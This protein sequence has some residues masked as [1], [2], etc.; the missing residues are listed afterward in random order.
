[1]TRF[2]PTG[3]IL[4]AL[5]AA[6]AGCAARTDVSTTGSTPAQFT[7][8]FITTQEVWFNKNSGATA[9]DSGWSKF[10]LNTPITVDLVQ[11][12]GT[13]A[14]VANDL[15]LGPGTYNSILLL[16]VTAVSPTASAQAAG[17]QFN[18]EADF[19]DSAGTHQVALIL[20]NPEK[21]IAVPGSLKVPVG[22]V[23][24]TGLGTP[25]STGTTNA[26]QTPFGAPTTVNPTTPTTI[27]TTTNNTVT[28]S[29]AASFDG[30]RDLHMFNYPTGT[31][32][33]T[34][35]TGVLLSASPTASD[36]STA[37]AISGT[38]SLTTI[39]N[40]PT[41]P[42]TSNT[43]SARTA[44]WASAET[45]SADGLHRV[46]VASAPV[47]SGGNFSIYPLNTSS[48]NPTVYDVVIHG[49]N[50]QTIII[51]GVS[52]TTTSPNFQFGANTTGSVNTTT[53]S[54]SVSLGTL[55]PTSTTSY[56]V[57]LT[58]NIGATL[59]GGAAITFYQTLP[60]DSA[61][62]VIDEVALDPVT[63]TLIPNSEA[64]STSIN[65]TTGSPSGVVTATFS[66]NGGTLSP[67]GVTPVE[68]SGVYGVGATAPLYTDG[69]P[70]STVSAAK[71]ATCPTVS[72]TTGSTTTATTT[73]APL[74]ASIASV[75]SLTPANSA[76][77]ASITASI[78]DSQGDDQGTL[79]VSRNGAVIGTA[80]L[81]PHLPS[82]SVT[83]NGLPGGNTYY[84]S[85]IVWNSHNPQLRYQSVATP[86]SLSGSTATASVEIIN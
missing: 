47:A 75:P 18:Q 13:L 51:K 60:G 50:I 12:D 34:V 58:G 72:T 86:V 5:C 63:N 84:L 79:L 29:F 65:S 32:T 40:V 19:A 25:T 77:T 82:G 62:Y 56:L 2:V 68:G 41:N 81:T 66:S 23:T 35:L 1:M 64:L 26:A 71:T 42:S 38:L 20:P 22:K 11:S 28:A 16:P 48:S 53:A 74:C 54:G 57:N 17:A 30:N 10:T 55:T 59:P 52:V 3:G 36:L 67:T 61:P 31:G 37:G 69:L 70:I 76:P 49:P 24:T 7:H 9:D 15:K 44:I 85:V 83:V 80:D 78:S 73:T 14:E 8:V 4:M 45:L 27:S 39:T 46:V 6:F 21:G 43:F 33:S